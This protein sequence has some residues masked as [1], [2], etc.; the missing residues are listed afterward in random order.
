MFSATKTNYKKMLFQW[1]L[2][3]GMI[4]I[5]LVALA[6]GTN[7]GILSV[8]GASSLTSSTVTVFVSPGV[9]AKS[10]HILLGYL[11]CTIA[12]LICFYSADALSQNYYES[13]VGGYQ[14]IFAVLAVAIT[15]LLMAIFHV[16]HPPAVGF[17]VGLVLDRWNIPILSIFIGYAVLLCVVR[18]LLRNRLVNLA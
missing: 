4:F 7:L 1:G 10:K 17:A 12:G 15:L 14:I 13:F 8:V 9:V 11:L 5:L 16:I 2:A 18:F 3:S 6:L